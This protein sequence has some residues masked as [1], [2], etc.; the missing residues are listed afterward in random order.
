[1]YKCTDDISGIIIAVVQ[2]RVPPGVP[3]RESNGDRHCVR[4]GGWGELT[5]WLCHMSLSSARALISF[6]TPLFSYATPLF[7]YATPLL[8]YAAPLLSYATPLLNFATPLLS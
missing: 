7:S 5:I 8:S 2:Q 4:Q 6:A 3:S 1:V